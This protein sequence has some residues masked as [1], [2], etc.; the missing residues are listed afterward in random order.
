MRQLQL[1]YLIKNDLHKLIKGQIKK[2][3]AFYNG[4]EINLPFFT[5]EQLIAGGTLELIMSNT[6]NKDWGKNAV[7]PMK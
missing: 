5:H 3:N 1:I 7:S 4:K 6:P 2:I